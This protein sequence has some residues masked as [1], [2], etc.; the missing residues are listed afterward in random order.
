MT[1][2]TANSTIIRNEDGEPLGFETDYGY[3]PD[4]DYAAALYEDDHDYDD[5]PDVWGD[6]EACIEQGYHRE[7]GNGVV[8]RPNEWQCA[9]CGGFYPRD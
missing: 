6:E 9:A 7:S 4:Y 1:F 5:E 8:G 3:E 2:P